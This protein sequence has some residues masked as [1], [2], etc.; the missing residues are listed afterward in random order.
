MRGPWL[1]WV[2][3]RTHPAL[4]PGIWLLIS[5]AT[6]GL[7]SSATP[8]TASSVW[9]STAALWGTILVYCLIPAYFA[10]A[11]PYLWQRTQSAVAQLSELLPDPARARARVQQV[12]VWLQL[13]GVVLGGLL[14]LLQYG[15]LLTSLWQSDERLL[16]LAMV[17]ANVIVW[18][19]IGW[20]LCWRLYSSS[21]LRSLGARL[22]VNL[23]DQRP[24]KPL[25]QVAMLDVLV[26]MG[27]VAMMPLQSLD[28]EFRWDNYRAGLAISVPAALLFFLLP[29][30]GVHR[31]LRQRRAQRCTEL[32][33]AINRCDHADIVRL[34]ALVDHLHSVRNMNTWPLDFRLL[35]RALF[36]LVIPPL[37]W[38]GAALVE[39]LVERFL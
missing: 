21:G 7:I 5:F 4:V 8:I 3:Q 1:V 23:Y 31:A 33:D 27:A 13:L 35:S 14:G 6:L 32:Q 25:V 2:A 39:K 11:T 18:M 26:V 34:H 9:S 28:A 17:V 37:A 29:L 16:E 10:F 30:L 19:I 15:G 24:L 20:V 36:Y 12:P 38:V 22:P